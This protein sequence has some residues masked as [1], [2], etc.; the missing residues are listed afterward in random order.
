MKALNIQ[1]RKVKL[2]K[3]GK[4]SRKLHR[5]KRKT[6]RKKG[7]FFNWFFQRD[8]DTNNMNLVVSNKPKRKSIYGEPHPLRKFIVDPRDNDDFDE[9][10]TDGFSI[11]FS[12]FSGGVKVGKSPRKKTAIEIHREKWNNPEFKKRL[13]A[14]KDTKVQ[15]FESRQKKTRKYGSY[16]KVFGERWQ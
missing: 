12:P 11:S 14:N 16:G 6:R 8:S 15:I 2:K 3:G 13:F 9:D 1:K 4:N 10:R 5:K 7:G